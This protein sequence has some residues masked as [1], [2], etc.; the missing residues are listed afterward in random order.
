MEEVEVRTITRTLAYYSGN[1]TTA[2]RSLGIGRNTLYRKM[3]EYGIKA[4]T[5]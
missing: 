2:A 5:N 3:K 4:T 1:I